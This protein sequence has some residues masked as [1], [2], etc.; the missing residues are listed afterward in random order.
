M[1]RARLTLLA[2]L[3]GLACGD[4]RKDAVAEILAFAKDAPYTVELQRSPFGSYRDFTIA[5]Q[6]ERLEAYNALFQYFD[7]KDSTR[8]EVY[9]YLPARLYGQLPITAVRDQSY[10]VS[11][12]TLWATV[13]FERPDRG[14][15]GSGLQLDTLM[16][17]AEATRVFRA[18]IERARA[19][20]KE[21][22]TAFLAVVMGPRVVTLN[23]AS[24]KRA[25]ARRVSLLSVVQ[26]RLEI[27]ARDARLSSISFEDFTELGTDF[28]GLVKGF[29]TPGT[30]GWYYDSTVHPSAEVQCQA[31]RD[32]DTTNEY[33]NLLLHRL[34]GGERTDFLC[35][36]AI[37]RTVAE[38]QR[39]RP[40]H[41]RVRFIGLVDQDTVVGPWRSVR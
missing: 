36:W 12:D 15:Q 41:F 19:Q 13:V 23:T 10:R 28:G 3:S 32:A 18:S 35:V 39:I 17:A 27:L 4:N 25:A 6:Q 20:L 29:V 37:G 33:G 11:G 31:W 16:G 7:P 38:W 9:R 34:H 24:S 14:L 2:V 5:V 22:D 21:V 1:D 8:A 26:S 30:A 40:N